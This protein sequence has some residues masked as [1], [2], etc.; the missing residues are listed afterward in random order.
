MRDLTSRLL[1]APLLLLGHELRAV[2]AD[3]VRARRPPMS[4]NSA[5]ITPSVTRTTVRYRCH[6]V[7][8]RNT[9][10]VPGGRRSSE[11]P[12]RRSCRQSATNDLAMG[13]TGGI[14]SPAST[15]KDADDESARANGLR[16]RTAGRNRRP[17]LHRRSCPTACTS[18]PTPRALCCRR[19]P[20]ARM[21]VRARPACSSRK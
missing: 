16:R 4:S 9:T 12:Q 1:D 19:C 7:G 11:S 3:A 10:S 2:C 17:R 18:G 20:T 21:P 14:R 6:S 5:M 8:S 13:S 15:S